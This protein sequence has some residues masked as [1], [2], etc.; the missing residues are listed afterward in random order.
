MN[1]ENKKSVAVIGAGIIGVN[2]AA[3]LQS[4][5]FDVTL[6]DKKAIGQGCSKGNAGHF[7]S[8]QVFPLAEV[9]I[10]WQLPKLLFDPLGP[11]ALSPRYLPRVL[12]WFLKFISN[13]LPSKRHANG[14]ALKTL[15]KEAI[16]YYRPLLEA[17]DAQHLLTKKGSLLVFEKTPI[18]SVEKQYHHYREAGIPVEL[19]NRKQIL[20]LEPNLSDKIQHGLYFTDVAHTAD[21][22]AICTSIAKYAQDQGA[23]YQRF[24]LK[25][26]VHTTNTVNLVGEQETLTFD[27]VVIACGAWSKPILNQLG[28]NLP[29]EAERGYSLNL[30]KIDKPELTRPVASADRRF[31]MTPMAQGLRLSGT[32]EFAGLKQKANKQR[33]DM[34]YQHAKDMLVN[35]APFDMNTAKDEQRWLGFRPSLP[36]SLPVIGQAPNHENIFFALGHQHLGLTQGAITGKLIGQIMTKQKTAVDI[37]PFC[38]SRFN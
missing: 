29:I 21:P 24:E 17:A 8:E 1:T 13:M 2:C 33:A 35:I 6:L 36:D 34:L 37:R 22:F 19:L 12:P 38:I 3:E 20:L 10:L 9:S 5:G 11:I 27:H 23:K 14:E 32:V 15:N 31:I 18:K 7:A 26:I 28:Y 30:E 25:S 4:Q 16:N